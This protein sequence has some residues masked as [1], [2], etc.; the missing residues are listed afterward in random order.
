[1]CPA[2]HF[3]DHT[4]SGLC[5]S[6]PQ[7]SISKEGAISLQECYCPFGTIDIESSDVFNCVDVLLLGDAVS[8]SS[9]ARTEAKVYTFAG[10]VVSFSGSLEMVHA[11][12]LGYMDLSARASLQLTE[13]RGQ[14]DY[15]VITSEEEEAMTLHAKMDSSVFEA[16]AFTTA[17]LASETAVTRH[18]IA[19]DVL[20]CPDGL[21]FVGGNLVRDQSDCKCAHGM[22]PREGE[23]GLSGGCQKCPAGKH[24]SAIADAAC[25]SCGGL[26]TLLEG[27]VSTSACTCPAGFVNEILDDPT[28]CQP[29]GR[30]FFCAGGRHKEPCGQSLTTATET[31]TDARECICASG[32]FRSDSNCQ[33]CLKGTFKAEI[34]DGACQP[35]VAGRW[36]NE[37]A[38]SREDACNFCTQGSTTRESGAEDESFC[39]KPEPQQ[40]VQCTS[41]TVCLIEITGF[42]L[43]DGHRLA[44]TESNCNTGKVAVSGVVA[45]G[46]S[47]PATSEGHRYVWG[48]SSVEFSPEG[49]IYNLCWCANM[50]DLQCGSLQTD[51]ILSA[52]KLEVIGPFRNHSLDCVRGQTCLGLRP[53]QGHQLSLEDRVAVRRACGGSEVLSLALANPNGTGSLSTFDGEFYLTFGNVLL[54][55]D[56]A[57][58]IC[59]CGGSCNTASDFAVPAGHLQVLGPYTNQRTNCF[60]GQPCHLQNIKGVGLMTGDRIMLR[61]DCETGPML[62]GSPGN[63]I[64]FRNEAWQR[65]GHGTQ[66]A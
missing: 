56:E 19:I 63:G 27:A 28:S 61:T 53:F 48:D 3:K 6:C 34:G 62:P 65:N 11:H 58:T 5:Q 9:F 60:L 1:M 2:G 52:G 38:A 32:F 33:P 15:K 23:S 22:E 31:A 35:C 45:Q 42:H 59:W 41:G 26:T 43:Q 46:V 7:Q 49:G 29:C 16:F 51:F 55:A 66:K 54:D 47:K 8:N 14:I 36:S 12:L 25:S 39:V 17:T 40:F 24:K 18:S 21:G 30:G 13:S 4:G 57:Y 37:S 10:S 44:V 50:R 20:H 64:A